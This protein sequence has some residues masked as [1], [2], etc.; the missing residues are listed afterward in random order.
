MEVKNVLAY[1]V[2]VFFLLI[3]FPPMYN[4]VLTKDMTGWTFSG[5]TAIA[6][7][8]QAFPYIFIAVVALVPAYYIIKRGRE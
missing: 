1:L 8:L 7:L 4:A 3:L 5:H 6:S 2:L